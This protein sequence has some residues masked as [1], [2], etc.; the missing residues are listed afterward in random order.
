MNIYKCLYNISKIS[1]SYKY[2]QEILVLC[3]DSGMYVSELNN[4]VSCQLGDTAQL[5]AKELINIYESNADL[6]CGLVRIIYEYVEENIL[7][8]RHNS[9]II[10]FQQLV[11][12]NIEDVLQGSRYVNAF[13]YS[14]LNNELMQYRKII[15][16]LNEEKKRQTN[17]QKSMKALND[18]Y[19]MVTKENQSLNEKIKVLND[20]IEL[21]QGRFKLKNKKVLCLSEINIGQD[22]EVIKERYELQCLKM[23]SSIKESPKLDDL[24]ENND[25]IILCTNDAKH[26]IFNKVKQN[27]K[28]F[29]T[30][31]TNLDKVFEEVAVRLGGLGNDKCE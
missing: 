11:D 5:Y 19:S 15:K 4:Y 16:Q 26:S 3:I 12:G 9:N 23:E 27:N 17:A 7:K 1:N 21:L 30:K 28:L 18:R 13:E 6:G 29:L 22:V 10:W 14:Q 8:L 25:I 31:T 24:I 2:I 20:R